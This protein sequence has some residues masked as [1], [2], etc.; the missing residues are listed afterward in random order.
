MGALNFP[1]IFCKPKTALKIRAINLKKILKVPCGPNTTH[2]CW[3]QLPVWTVDL[4]QH[5]H[6]TDGKTEDQRREGALPVCKI[7]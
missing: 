6:F 1:L 4:I 3:I 7:K 5:P 2:A